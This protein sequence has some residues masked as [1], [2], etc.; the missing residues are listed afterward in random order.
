MSNQTQDDDIG[1]LH[2]PDEAAMRASFEA[3]GGDAPYLGDFAYVEGVVRE[4]IAEVAAA[5]GAGDADRILK[6]TDDWAARFASP[7]GG[8]VGIADWHNARQ[9]GAYIVRHWPVEDGLSLEDS[10]RSMFLTAVL[11]I[12]DAIV[13]NAAGKRD[14]E[15]LK[16]IIDITA[17]ELTATLTGTWEAVY[18]E[19]DEEGS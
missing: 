14:D 5:I 19:E 4:F 15:W 2:A 11:R 17:E 12:K 7:S 8:E 16:F 3:A 9:L 1:P 13:D 6:A 18:P 10:L